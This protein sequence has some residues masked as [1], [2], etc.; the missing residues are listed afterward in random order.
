M[1]VTNEFLQK[2]KEHKEGA[3]RQKFEGVLKDYLQ[4]IEEAEATP[5]LAHK[6]L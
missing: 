4:L 6:R 5:V 3:K 1:G 2:I